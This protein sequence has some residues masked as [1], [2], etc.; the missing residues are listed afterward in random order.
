MGGEGHGFRVAMSILNNGRTGLGGGCVGAM[1]RLIALSVRQSTERKQ[2][3]RPISEFA[4]IKEKIAQ[5]AIDCFAAE[6][7]V[8]MVAHYI[9]SGVE[10]YSVEAAI[11][12]VF[13]TEAVWRAA[14][15]ALQ[16]AGGN[17]FMREYP[18]EQ[19]VRDCRINR[20]FEG[21]NEILR[22]YIGL[23]GMKDAGEYL[24]EIGKSAGKIFNDP[25]KGFGVLSGYV[26]K[27]FTQLT[28][29][30]RDKIVFINEDLRDL[31]TAFEQYTVKVSSTVDATLKR[32]GKDIVG[33]QLITKRV[34]DSVSDLF[35]GLC[36]MSRVSSMVQEKGAKACA[37]EISM[38]R[39]FAKQA[40]RRISQNI[41]RIE[42][43]EDPELLLLADR[44]LA[45]G[46]SWD[47][48]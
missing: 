44:I 24:K 30:G 25:I 1:K 3:G 26:T 29:V 4:L 32:L 45:E 33:S 17:G 7:V 43:N 8:A 13:A 16:I 47:I 14:D 19:V 42:K 27:R 18:Y 9:D 37:W 36:V 40:C 41:R 20:I 22:L 11:S 21:T 6:S 34:A 28:S 46:Y 35:I 10:D 39:M 2:F 38:A 5:M 12:K 48:F 23:S 15:E 31:A